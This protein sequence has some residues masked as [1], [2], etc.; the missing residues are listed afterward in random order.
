[1]WG[2]VLPPSTDLPE[3]STRNQ[4]AALHH[5]GACCCWVNGV[6]GSVGGVSGTVQLKFYFGW[7]TRG[8]C[9][10]P[11][12]PQCKCTRCEVRSHVLPCITDPTSVATLQQPVLVVEIR[13]YSV[14]CEEYVIETNTKKWKGMDW[15]GHNKKRERERRKT[16]INEVNRLRHIWGAT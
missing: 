12:S 10:T 9:T 15:T 4:T 16:C 11:T 6:E 7:L 8:V 5:H 2:T 13:H 1:M 3:T 14:R